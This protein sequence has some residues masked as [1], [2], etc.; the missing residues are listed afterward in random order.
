MK[1]ILLIF[2]GIALGIGRNLPFQALYPFGLSLV[3]LM[4]LS[5]A[6]YLLFHK[7]Q[8]HKDIKL[9]SSLMAVMAFFFTISMMVNISEYPPKVLDILEIMR[10]FFLAYLVILLSV[11]YHEHSSLLLV[12]FIVGVLITFYF[13]YQNPMNEDVVGFVQIFNPNVL[14]VALVVSSYML[15][16]LQIK[17]NGVAKFVGCG[18]LLYC[19]VFTYSKGAWLL[20][21]SAF[22]VS[23]LL[24]LS[25]GNRLT[26]IFIGF[27]LVFVAV[28]GLSALA[29][30]AFFVL[31]QAKISATDF[32]ATAAS[33]GSFSARVGLILS[34][35]LMFVDNPFFGVGLSGWEDAHKAQ[36][37]VLGHYFYSDD[38]P[39]SAFFYVL[40]T[41]GG[42]AFLAWC[43]IFM[44]FLR[45]VGIYSFRTL[46]R[47]S[48]RAFQ[49]FTILF[50]LVAGNT[51]SEMLSAYYYWVVIVY[52]YLGSKDSG[53][54]KVE[55]CTN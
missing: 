51:Q 20:G 41:G 10:F 54:L 40:S 13:S 18:V 9:I 28:K 30:S 35:F 29:D 45:R 16:L 11:L 42:F 31:L 27:C 3:E 15:L 17:S 5:C 48:A 52:L 24:L 32:G 36:A 8:V 37:L 7:M 19:S 53:G 14:G 38:N 46:T 22:I 34:A 47:S 26:Q 4:A 55:D 44:I 50:F 21:S 49:V 2:F 39:N 25:A 1:K 12:S 43:S 6:P 23:S 33:G